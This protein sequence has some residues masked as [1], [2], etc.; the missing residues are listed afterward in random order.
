[1]TVFRTDSWTVS[2]SLLEWLGKWE[3]DNGSDF[4][5]T[6]NILELGSGA[7][8]QELMKI[9]GEGHVFSIEQNE[10]WLNKYHDNYIHAPLKEHKPIKNHDGNLWYDARILEK[11]LPKIDYDIILVD[12]PC[13]PGGRAGFVKYFDLFKHDVPIVFDD[14][15]RYRDFKIIKSI[16][17]RLEKPFTVYGWESKNWGVIE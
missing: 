17:G 7:G 2:D 4:C 8:T 5:A 3:I 14:L 9:F 13:P 6:L 1:L 12:G 16:S 15:H 11:E 10:E